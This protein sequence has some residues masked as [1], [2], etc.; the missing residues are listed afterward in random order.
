MADLARLSLNQITT[1]NLDLR[2]AADAC[3]RHNVPAIGLWRDKV[4]AT[5]LH[6]SAKIVHDAGLKVSSLCR[7]GFFPA[8]SKEKR[9]ANIVDNLRAIDEA[10]ILNAPVL[11]LVCGGIVNHDAASS[12]SMIAD[13]IG[14]ITEHAKKCGVKLGIEPLNPMFAA[15][16]SIICSLEEANDLAEKFDAETVGVI[17]DVFHLWFDAHVLREIERAGKR[18]AGFHVSDWRVPLP[19]IL[20]SRAMMGDGVIE[21]KKLRGAVEAAGY[22]DF[23]EVE[24][25]NRA[26]WDADADATMARM[27][28]TFDEFV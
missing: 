20:L 12:R 14:E 6:E 18:I 4:A 17:V 24:I 3:A 10:A 8:E 22:N 28:E 26:I 25:F 23:I 13:G 7:G 5:G 11:V 27:C 2:E 15:D 1:N 9:A 16:R 19:D 21:F